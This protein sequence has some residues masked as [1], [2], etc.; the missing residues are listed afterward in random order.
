MPRIKS[1]NNPPK[2]PIK[3]S[4][5]TEKS[6]GEVVRDKAKFD[7]GEV[8]YDWDVYSDRKTGDKKGNIGLGYDNDVN[9]VY[10]ELEF[11]E[12]TDRLKGGVE[13]E[14]TI[15]KNRSVRA[16]GSVD[17]DGNVAGTVGG[18]HAG[19]R[20]RVDAEIGF[21]EKTDR[22]HGKV[23]GSYKVAKDT[24]VRGSL[25]V[26]NKRAPLWSLGARH[27]VDVGNHVDIEGGRKSTLGNYWGGDWVRKGDRYGND[28]LALKWSEKKG[29][30]FFYEGM[31]RGS[32]WRVN[33][34]NELENGV[35]ET[36]TKGTW[37]GK[38]ATYKGDIEGKRFADGRTSGEVRG[39]RTDGRNELMG[40]VAKSKDD[41]Y[42]VGGS[43]ARNITDNTKGTV[44]GNI[45]SDESWD[46]GARADH[47]LTDRVTVNERIKLDSDGVVTHGHGAEYRLN[48]TT[49]VGA[50]LEHDNTGRRTYTLSGRQAGDD[51][52]H[53]GKV[54]HTRNADG[55]RGT[56][57]KYS[58]DSDNFDAAVSAGL[59]DGNAH[60][61][62]SATHIHKN[63]RN[64]DTFDVN[65]SEDKGLEAGGKIVRKI[66]EDT[67][68]D[69]SV[70][71]NTR[72]N[73]TSA[74]VGVSTKLGDDDSVKA[75]VGLSGSTKDEAIGGDVAL[76]RTATKDRLGWKANVAGERSNKK[77]SIDLGGGLTSKNLFGI[78]GL[79]TSVGLGGGLA[80]SK[81]TEVTSHRGE[82]GRLREAVLEEAGEGA[83]FVRYGM[84]GKAKADIGARIPVGVG[85]VD[86][87]YKY[88]KSYEVEFT[89]LST[90]GTVGKRPKTEELNLPDGTAGVLAM[91]AGES[92]RITGETNHVVKGG[93]GVGITAGS[94]ALGD[95]GVSAGGNLT[96]AI[97]G[98]TRTEV[99]RGGETS[100]RMVV[101]AAD[102]R[103]KAGGFEAKVGFTPNIPV[104]KDLGPVAEVAGDVATAAIR[105]WTTIGVR[106]GVEKT[107]GDERLLDARIDLSNPEA[108]AAYETAMKGDWSELQRLSDNG[109]PGVTIDKSIIAEIDEVVKPTV[110]EG[111][112]MSLETTSGE[113]LKESD[114]T[115]KGRNFDVSSDLDTNTKAKDGWFKDKDFSVSDYSRTVTAEDGESTGR[116]KGE[117]HYMSW[118]S[119]SSDS[120]SSKDEVLGK[121]G[122][123]KYVL[124][125]D[126]PKELTAYEGKIGKLKEHRKL[127][128]GPRNELR[129]TEVSTEITFSD[130]GLDRLEGK[131]ED[132]IWSAY[133]SSWKAMNP[134]KSA[135]DW[136]DST[137][138]AALASG[139]DSWSAF[140]ETPADAYERSAYTTAASFVGD[141]AKA[142]ALPEEARNDAVRQA[143]AS[144]PNQ[145]AAVGT[146]VDLI[147][148][149]AV[150][151]DLKIDS[152]AGRKGK[153][154]DF[155]M[156]D[157]GDAYN[158]HKTVFGK[159][160]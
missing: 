38:N 143:L 60:V 101:S 26:D 117:E 114:V 140:G 89:K 76:S 97:K 64:K 17:N 157:K 30:G 57:A 71:R 18:K 40:R 20:H 66:G 95:V 55:T 145:S 29:Y 104:N 48:D 63:R 50:D 43:A 160:L 80:V 116:I 68:L 14:H 96:Y 100:A 7:N 39:T 4:H 127:W 65:W 9:D 47:K 90:D 124:G 152:N 98:K 15:D 118:R 72:S 85:Y 28:N 93:A 131:S 109:H 130:S 56:E 25:N 137:K 42:T 79:K 78:D 150:R 147:G 105:K 106:R 49:H 19:E 148:R 110:I 74:K 46:I 102:S 94:S 59:N 52:E 155:K 135:P 81:K 53:R 151:L 112:G 33:T 158:V 138:R 115:H 126:V 5:T 139:T 113:R 32:N 1:G 82:T 107:T 13:V 122:L 146:L 12:K 11:N 128:I 121:I 45:S 75:R 6:G 144:R 156:S 149:D 23:K 61:A 8:R 88:G 92:V 54:S 34:R 51:G 2:Q 87:G 37:D 129:N 22:L 136:T 154:F 111:L 73:D 44:T 16:S 77:V 91:K 62:G 3:S 27:R 133:A 153:Q 10:A 119:A 41:V 31:R 21:N 24:S 58:Y 84:K 36:R 125:D 86:A 69:A 70:R 83:K 35:F 103:T 141:L 132:Q 159:D 142:S 99:T 123:A 67:D 134:G 108:S 120:F